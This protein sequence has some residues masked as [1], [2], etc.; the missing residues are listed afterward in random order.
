MFALQADASHWQVWQK[1]LKAALKA[2]KI[3]G[4]EQIAMNIAIYHDE[5]DVE[6]LPAY[7]NWTLINLLK[8]DKVKNTLVEPYLPNYKIGIMHLAAG[9]WKNG[10][11][12]RTDKN[13]QV[14]IK[15]IDNKKVIKSLRFSN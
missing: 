14:E 13:I 3:W 5:L 11:D 9:I 7:C 4:S 10:K 2:G 1:N 12:M 6:I 8:F 15:T